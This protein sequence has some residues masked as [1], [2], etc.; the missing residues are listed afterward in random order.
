[1][2][3]IRFNGINALPM[4]SAILLNI[5]IPTKYQNAVESIVNG[6]KPTNEYEI[7]PYRERRSLSANA[8]AW[9]LADMLADKL[10]TTKEE[11]YRIAISHVGVFDEFTV[12]DENAAKRFKSIW[13]NN[14]VGWLT[15]TINETTIQAYYGS[16]TYDTKEMAR[17][18]DFLQEECRI[19]NIEVRPK[20]E[21]DAMLEQWGDK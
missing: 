1:M 14:G 6:F 8:Y 2:T 20:W 11:I 7:K 9:K 10:H 13:H 12:S 19:Q 4:G 5:S 21:V 18:I 17:L 3:R 15:K 16:S